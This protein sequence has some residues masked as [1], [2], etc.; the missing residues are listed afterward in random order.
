MK[1]CKIDSHQL[2]FPHGLSCPILENS[3]V[4]FSSLPNLKLHSKEVLKTRL[5]HR[6]RDSFPLA[7]MN[8]DFEKQKGRA[9]EHRARE[10]AGPI[11]HALESIYIGPIFLVL[12]I[13]P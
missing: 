9:I 4:L 10:I 3:Q 11:A 2:S 12:C 1:N 5:N 6:N 7:I 8:H 13:F